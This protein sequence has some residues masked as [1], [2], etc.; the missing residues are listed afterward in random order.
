VLS[1][2]ENGDEV[3][4]SVLLSI[5]FEQLAAEKWDSKFELLKKFVERKNK[6]LQN[7]SVH[8]PA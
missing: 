6:N 7:V 3:S 2:F 8:N 1:P 4:V 5:S